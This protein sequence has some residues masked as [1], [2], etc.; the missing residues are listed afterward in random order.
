MDWLDLHTLFARHI[1]SVQF[2]QIWRREKL[3]ECRRIVSGNTQVDQH[4]IPLSHCAAPIVNLCLCVFAHECVGVCVCL[5]VWLVYLHKN[6]QCSHEHS[7]FHFSFLNS[8][9]LIAHF[10]GSFMPHLGPVCIMYV[11]VSELT[12]FGFDDIFYASPDSGCSE[13]D[14]RDRKRPIFLRLYRRIKMNAG[15]RGKLSDLVALK[16]TGI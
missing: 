13:R 2:K 7:F 10:W 5:L 6:L 4:A 3:A 14:V 11:W 1:N 8:I 9:P 12:R 16:P 15:R